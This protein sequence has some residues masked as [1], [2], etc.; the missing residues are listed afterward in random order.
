[1]ERI[2]K[3]PEMVK[4]LVEGW[5]DGRSGAFPRDLT[6]PPLA[7][8]EWLPWSCQEERTTEDALCELMIEVMEALAGGGMQECLDRSPDVDEGGTAML[9]GCSLGF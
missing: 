6:E 3:R 9:E 5:R 4:D 1:M 8:T 7:T 2:K